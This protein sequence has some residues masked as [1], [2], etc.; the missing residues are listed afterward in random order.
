MRLDEAFDIGGDFI[1]DEGSNSVAELL[2]APTAVALVALPLPGT[3][4]VEGGGEQR[5]VDRR[6]PAGVPDEVIP[7]TTLDIVPR[8]QCMDL[9][10]EETRR[11]VDHQRTDKGKVQELAFQNG[12]C[13]WVGI[14]LQFDANLAGGSIGTEVTELQN[15]HQGVFFEKGL[16]D[17][18]V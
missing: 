15:S 16:S 4:L 8:Q 5:V 1:P 7:V 13:R 2:D 18:C 11:V 3:P 6:T 14:D 17:R 12:A 10:G 9:A